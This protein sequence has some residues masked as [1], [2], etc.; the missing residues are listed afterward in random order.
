[1]TYTCVCTYL[2]LAHVSVH[3]AYQ[4]VDVCIHETTFPSEIMCLSTYVCTY[5]RMYA[6]NHVN[7][8]DSVRLRGKL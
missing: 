7:F 8:F 6:D 2:F 1:V 5:I 3:A 4:I